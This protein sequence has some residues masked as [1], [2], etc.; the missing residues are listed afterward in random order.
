MRYALRVG[1][2]ILVPA[3][4]I[5]H[6]PGRPAATGHGAA[7][8]TRAAPQF[9]G[10]WRLVSR[11]RRLADGTTRPHPLSAAYLVYVD[12]T[13][14]CYVA[15]DPHRPRWGSESAPTPAEAVTT[16]AGLYAY[17]GTVEVHRAEGFVVHHVEIDKVPN[18]VGR[19]LTRWFTFET[20]DRLRL[21]V[22]AAELSP[23]VVADELLWERVLR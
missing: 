20:P 7:A 23:P 6:G 2:L 13:R 4:G 10:M 11:V 12:S 5:A 3:L 9:A 15:M 16:L 19:A 22:D 14:M 1:W 17:C 8:P 18:L 21:R